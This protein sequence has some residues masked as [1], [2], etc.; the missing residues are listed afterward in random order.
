MGGE[1]KTW[2]NTWQTIEKYAKSDLD[3]PQHSCSFL[4]SATM[5]FN[6]LYVQLFNEQTS[7]AVLPI[8]DHWGPFNTSSSV[9]IC[10]LRPISVLWATVNEAV[11]SVVNVFGVFG[12]P[13]TAC[14]DGTAWCPKRTHIVAAL[15]ALINIYL[16]PLFPSF[17]SWLGIHYYSFLTIYISPKHRLSWCILNYIRIPR[18]PFL[19]TR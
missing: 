19:R 12:W 1:G 16:H 17:P 9:V 6:F 7:F 15:F 14:Q 3:I 11:G 10:W 8:D 13:F 4:T 18:P 5:T 2:T